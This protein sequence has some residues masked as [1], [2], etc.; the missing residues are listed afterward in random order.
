MKYLILIFFFSF[1]TINAQIPAETLEIN[2]QEDIVTFTNKNVHVN[3]CS[4]FLIEYELNG[5]TLNVT[6]TDTSTI[7][8]KCY[9]NFELQ[10]SIQFLSPGKYTLNLYRQE[11]KKYIYPEDTLILVA[12][13]QFEAITNKKP[14][15]QFNYLQSPCGVNSVTDEQAQISENVSPNPSNDFITIPYPEGYKQSELTRIEVFNVM[16][17]SVLSQYY[18]INRQLNV[19]SLPTG[20]YFIK[21]DG[22]IIRF[23]KI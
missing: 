7:K 4:I 5:D 3:C 1:I 21:I 22:K 2:S 15:V 20:L 13:K 9:C 16:G 6:E 11:L 14:V 8:C 17:E 23:A 10:F 19:Q 18:N 12:Q